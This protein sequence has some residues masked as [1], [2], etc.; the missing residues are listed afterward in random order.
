MN[1]DHL[2]TVYLAS[3]YHLV[4]TVF[5]RLNFRSAAPQTVS[6]KEHVNC[7]RLDGDDLKCIPPAQITG[8]LILR[9]TDTH[10]CK[11]RL[12]YSTYVSSML[13]V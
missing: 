2:D 6:E 3:G 7:F 12:K 13:P 5:E 10:H 8:S 1:F 11:P 4:S 9:H